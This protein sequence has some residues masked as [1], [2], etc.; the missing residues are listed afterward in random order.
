MKKKKILFAV[1]T[2]MLAAAIAFCFTLKGE[3]N[4]LACQAQESIANILLFGSEAKAE[5]ALVPE[6]DPY[7]LI[8]S[9]DISI[10]VFTGETL[11]EFDLPDNEA[12]R[13][14]ANL[15]AG[16]NLGNTF[17]AHDEKNNSLGLRLETYWCG[18]KTTRELFHALKTAG[19]NLVRI[20]V[21][22]HNHVT[23]DDYSIDPEWMA[24]VKEVAQW[25]SDED[26]YFIINIHHDNF[27]KYF[28]P[29]DEHAEQSKKYLT[30]I[31][32]Q[33]AENFADFDDHCILESLNEPR[34]VGKN[35]E[36]YVDTNLASGRLAIQY[37]NQ[38]NQMFVEIIRGTGGNNATRYL[39]V[40]GYCASPA[41]VLSDLFVMPKDT[42]ENRI[43]ISVHAYTPYSFALDKTNPDSSFDLEEDK[44]KKQ[45]IASFM[46]NLYKKY[47]S[48]GIPV[49]IDEFGALQKKSTDLQARV[50]FTAYYIASA[51]TRGITCCWWDNHAFTGDGER[52]GIID[53]N[54]IEWKYPDIALA[55]LR[56]CTFNREQ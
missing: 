10:P 30:A 3:K 32:T 7:Q 16:W 12:I 56:N 2:V 14:V 48:N 51:S 19:F 31:W 41:G 6:E 4:N 25:A 40:P 49:I 5:A 46:N 43:I 23:G 26:M 20:P 8:Q 47:V 33:I 45:E 44:G 27:E 28:Y 50:N 17:D 53:R 54:A 22:W 35:N 38:W 37:I 24:R 1:I 9:E 39:S 36:W 34:L 55:I 18:A 15:K 21:S 52:F 13:F 29:D 11:K 42:A